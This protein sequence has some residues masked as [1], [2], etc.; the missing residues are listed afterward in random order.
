[1][2][3]S[4]TA[5]SCFPAAASAPARW[6]RA[7]AIVTK[8]VPPYAIV[9]GNP[10]RVV[11]QRFPDR[12]SPSACSGWRGG[13]GAT[14]GCAPPCRISARLPVEE[15]LDKYEP[16]HGGGMTADL[17]IEGGRALIGDALDG[18]CDRRRPG[19]GR[20]SICGIG[21]RS[22]RRRTGIDARGL[23]VLPGIVDIHGDAFER[24]MMPRPGVDFPID[25]ALLDTD[26]QVVANGITTVFHGVT[27]SWEPGLR[28]AGNARGILDAHGAAAAAPRRRHALPPAP[29]DLQS[30]CRGRGRRLADAQAA[31][32]CWRSTT[33]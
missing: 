7:G 33:T 3:G 23:L 13:T 24:Q 16:L 31:S 9:A 27:W 17:R 32:T 19:S 26:R 5:P 6:S 14:S 15:F 28:G 1:M 22:A 18:R 10:A 21:G 20:R 12:T 2:S 4:A 29:R 11:R 30:R 25:I 8:D